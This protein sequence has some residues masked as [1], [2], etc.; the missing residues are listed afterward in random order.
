[1]K[2]DYFIIESIPQD[3]ITDGIIFNDCLKSTRQFNPVYRFVKDIAE[4]NSAMREYVSSGYKY[5]FISSHGDFEN[6]NLLDGVI[7]AEDI[8]DM[9]LSFDGRRIFMSTCQGG[10]YLFAKS[11]IRKGAYSV[12]GCPDSLPQIIAVAMWTTMAAIL[13]E[14]V[15]LHYRELDGSVSLLA[16]IY[17]IQLK[18]FSFIR[19]ESS[20]KEYTYERNK[21]RVRKVYPI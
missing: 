18:Y 15:G 20:M 3:D 16:D 14:D 9:P 6:I 21:E 8:A 2:S 19:N 11:F 10:S 7:N 4:F 1:M 17:N 13:L 5:L 12:V